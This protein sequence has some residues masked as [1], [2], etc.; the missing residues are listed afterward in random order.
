MAVL[1]L[2]IYME[3]TPNLEQAVRFVS[4]HMPPPISLDF[5]KV[6]W[7]VETKKFS[8]IKE[9]LDNYV[10]TWKDWDNEFV[11]SIQLIESSLLEPDP[12]KKKEVFEKAVQ[13]TLDGT[14]DHMINYAH[15]LQSPI[16]T[17]HML[18]IVLPVMGMVMLP[19]IGA[20]LGE[21][22]NVWALFGL[23]N[24]FLPIIVYVIG[25]QVLATRPAGTN[26]ED[27]YLFIRQKYKKGEFKIGKATFRLP[28]WFLGLMTF[29]LVGMPAMIYLPRGLFLEGVAYRDF[30]YG[31]LALYASIDLVAAIGLSLGVY[32]W[33]SVR[34]LIPLKRSISSMESEFASATFQ[35][36]NRLEEKIPAEVAIS[37]VAATMA[38]SDAAKLFQL[39]DYNMKEQGAS[40]RE[41]IYNPKF[42][43]LV[44]YPST[45]IKSVMDVLIEG[46]KKGPVIV[47]KSLLTISKYLRSVH[48]VE[49]RLKDLLADTV[50]S[51]TMQ[52]KMFVPLIA[53]IVVG[54]ASLT[55][56]IMLNLG[57][58][59]GG[60]EGAEATGGVGTGLL[61][62]FQI[63]SMIPPFAFQSIIGLYVVQLILLLSFLLSGIIN[64][65]DR[66]EEQYLMAQNL[67]I[68]TLFYVVITLVTTLL[69]GNLAGPLTAVEYG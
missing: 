51:M 24:I 30:I 61:D 23:Y 18:G 19:M 26:A 2:I 66:V 55:T 6:L 12:E 59:L 53:G 35:L 33:W 32:Y 45:L 67:F 60:F 49:E 1:Y 56:I 13:V 25:K 14:Q 27:A 3:H 38:K 4:E 64:G 39:I 31:N 5:M 68:A 62:V 43:A 21:S 22:V 11:E 29:I 65:H 9:S 17:L 16:Q 36:G 46:V 48:K 28:P 52:V 20:F 37:R 42:G 50:S 44:Y 58:R 15:S 69:F 41:A 57:T 54:L 34:D 8:N 10:E 7:D 40:L 47:G 63:E